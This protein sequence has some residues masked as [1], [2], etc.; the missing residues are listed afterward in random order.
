M[1]KLVV[2]L[3]TDHLAV[4]LYRNSEVQATAISVANLEQWS[5]AVAGQFGA[6]G[7][8]QLDPNA[9]DIGKRLKATERVLKSTSEQTVFAVGGS[10]LQQKVQEL[11]FFGFTNVF[12]TKADTERFHES[13]TR[14]WD[15]LVWPTLS[16]EEQ[17]L[18]NL[19]WDPP[20]EDL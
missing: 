5:A 19:P 1:N 12:C 2:L 10:D 7:V 13:T 8:I 16:L 6:I 20:P 3:E 15:S 14:Y 17:T 18:A 11:L 9:D 4:G